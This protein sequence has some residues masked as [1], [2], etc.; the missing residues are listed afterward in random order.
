MNTQI[1]ITENGTTTLATA[2]KYCDR[3][4][5]VNVAVPNY[6]EEVNRQKAIT[7]SILDR[8]ITDYFNDSVTV[9]Y[10]G[11]FR[12]AAVI[13]AEFTQQVKL[14]NTSFS[15]CAALVKFILRSESVCTLQSI[16]AFSRT[17]IESGTGYIYVPDQL[18]D[19]YK[20]AT[21]WVT[22]ADQIKPI[23]KLEG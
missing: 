7:D 22:Y 13:R 9:V 20:T 2:G 21:N 10:T 14:W 1:N 3:N 15:D 12:Y 18:V 17:P 23:S 11:A 8:T 6:E 16:G 19:A 5:D 4:I